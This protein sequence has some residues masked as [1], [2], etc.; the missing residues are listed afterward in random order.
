MQRSPDHTLPT[1]DGLPLCLQKKR[2]HKECKIKIAGPSWSDKPAMDFA[3]LPGSVGRDPG[4]D[5]EL[6]DNM[7]QPARLMAQSGRSVAKRSRP[8]CS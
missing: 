6:Q 2:K 7:E 4:Y 1:R 8:A 3:D 5:Y